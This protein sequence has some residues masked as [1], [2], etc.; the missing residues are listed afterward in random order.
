M[1][2]LILDIRKKRS[3]SY[4]NFTDNNYMDLE[5][6]KTEYLLTDKHLESIP[7]L[8]RR[9]PYS[10]TLST[11]QNIDVVMLIDVVKK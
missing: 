1:M 7:K 4:K 6:A 5:R 10:S 11:Y 2:L 8:K 9:N 3:E